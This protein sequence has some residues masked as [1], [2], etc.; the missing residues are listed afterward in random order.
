MILISSFFSSTDCFNQLSQL[1]YDLSQEHFAYLPIDPPKDILSKIPSELPSFLD[2]SPASRDLRCAYIRHVISK[3]ITYRVFQPFLFTLGR[4]YDKADTFFQMLSMDIRRKSVRR[5]AFWRQ[6]TLKAAY[7]TSDAKQSINVAAAVIVDEIIDH[8]RHFADPKH[9]D[10]LLIAVRKIVKLAAETW[11]HARVERELVLALFPAP[12]SEDVSN[13]QWMEYGV[14][15]ETSPVQKSDPTRHVVL[16]TFP[17]VVREAAHEDFAFAS[18]ERASPC[19]YSPGEVLFSDSPVI[20]ARLQ[21]L[22]KKSTDTLVNQGEEGQLSPPKTPPPKGIEKLVAIR[23]Q[24][25]PVK[26]IVQSAPN[27]PKGG[28]AKA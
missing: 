21:E 5:E 6:Q 8:I 19:T 1:I 10:S 24:T 18:G 7:T 17:C 27:S 9:L 12:D 28:F 2:N 26:L 14:T 22:A 16:R 11:R 15:K 20:M 4:R 13:E 3:T 23:S 25:P